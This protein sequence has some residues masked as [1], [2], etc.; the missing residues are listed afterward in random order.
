MLLETAAKYV[1]LRPSMFTLIAAKQGL[2]HWLRYRLSHVNPVNFGKTGREEQFELQIT[3]QAKVKP[4]ITF[5]FLSA[6]LLVFQ[7]STVWAFTADPLAAGKGRLST[8][9]TTLMFDLSQKFTLNFD[10]T[11]HFV[12]F[13]QKDET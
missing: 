4:R 1:F 5:L 3:I 12:L 7:C 9:K 11:K 2:Y 10:I 6:V 8:D 13:R